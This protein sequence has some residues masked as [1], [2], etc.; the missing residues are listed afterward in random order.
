MRK[1]VSFEL[2][3]N[4]EDYLT[5]NIKD[6]MTI[7]S[8]TGLSIIEIFRTLR[9]EYIHLRQFIKYYLS[10]IKSVLKTKRKNRLLLILLI[11]HLKTERRLQTLVCHYEG[12]FGNR[13]LWKKAGTEKTCS[14]KNT[15]Q[16]NTAE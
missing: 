16:T 4:K 7:E 12:D 15:K 13:Y 8:I 6:L 5:L 1:T 10:L 3:G 2:F 14:K 11:P 9:T